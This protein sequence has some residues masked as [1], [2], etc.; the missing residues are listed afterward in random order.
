M[1]TVVSVKKPLRRVPGLMIDS[2]LPGI[3]LSRVVT[4]RYG[5][6]LAGDVRESRGTARRASRAHTADEGL[7]LVDR[8]VRVAGQR[9]QVVD[10]V[11]GVGR[12]EA[13]MPRQR[14]L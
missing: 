11:A 3:G 8:H 13:P 9:D 4:V 6:A 7:A 2:S 12:A 5:A 1:H 14:D 10:R